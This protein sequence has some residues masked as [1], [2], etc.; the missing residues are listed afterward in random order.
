M[1]K[2]MFATLSTATASA[3][4]G[5]LP[6]RLPTAANPAIAIT[7]GATSISQPDPKSAT[8]Q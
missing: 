5:T 3:T 2:A 6:R 4:S 7:G 8:E 1:I